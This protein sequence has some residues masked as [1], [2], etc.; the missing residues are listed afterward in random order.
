MKA[1]RELVWVQT[2]ETAKEEG[3]VPLEKEL[4]GVKFRR[5][6][7]PSVQAPG[8]TFWRYDRASPLAEEASPAR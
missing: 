2:P 3:E 1:S 8:Y 5:A 4:H 6:S 7:E